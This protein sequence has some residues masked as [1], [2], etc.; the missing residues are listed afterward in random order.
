MLRLS[1]DKKQFLYDFCWTHKSSFAVL[2]FV[3]AFIATP[4]ACSWQVQNATLAAQLASRSESLRVEDPAKV[5]LSALL[6]AE[7]LIRLPTPEADHTLRSSLALL[8][9]SFRTVTHRGAI[10]SL[11]LSPDGLWLA[12]GSDDR[13]AEVVLLN[14]GE[15]LAPLIHE[16]RITQVEFSPDGALLASAGGKTIKILDLIHKRELPPITVDGTVLLLSFGGSNRLAVATSHFVTV[17]NALTHEQLAEF[18]R[19]QGVRSVRV[20]ISGRFIAIASGTT[21]QVSSISPKKDFPPVDTGGTARLMRFNPAGTLVAIAMTEN[22][23]RI[24]NTATGVAFGQPL[25]VQGLISA[26]AFSEDGRL[27]AVAAGNTVVIF[28]VSDHCEEVSQIHDQYDILTI[29]FVG[30]GAMIAVA[31]G[32]RTVQVFESRS[33]RLIVNFI[34]PGPVIAMDVSNRPVPTVAIAAGKVAQVFSL[35]RGHNAIPIW[36]HLKIE[37]AAFSSNGRLIITEKGKA[38][39]LNV[40]NGGQLD[41]VPG[42]DYPISSISYSSDARFIVL[43]KEIRGGQ[44]TQ[45]FESRD[46]GAVLQSS[47]I[48]ATAVVAS[49]FSVDGYLL[50]IAGDNTRS[51][52]GENQAYLR[53]FRPSPLQQGGGVKICPGL[54]QSVAVSPN[55]Q[56]AAIGTS[57]YLCMFRLQQASEFRANYGKITAIDFS[58]DNHLIAIGSETGDIH[59]MDTT[60]AEVFNASNHESPVTA[61]QFD[62]DSTTLASLTSNGVLRVFNVTRKVQ[63]NRFPESRVRAFTF[64]NKHLITLLMDEPG[65]ILQT[66]PLSSGDLVQQACSILSR[67]LSRSEWNMYLGSEPYRKT[68]RNLP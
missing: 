64:R 3:Y 35:S 39:V 52:Y 55:H 5:E 26:L 43:T 59:V 12:T 8:R 4:T 11:S 25:H 16:H 47:D 20:D 53:I 15:S 36:E 66:H 32:N 63:I 29:A 33:T 46:G 37:R 1:S 22:S 65:P 14:T 61:V 23:V 18:D 13:T 50:A 9:K 56:F 49:A 24:Y 38:Y 42:S 40:E 31:H 54:A 41:I 28:M 2:I 68:C 48:Q 17:Y 45:L 7:S 34:H 19:K 51:Q 44:I 57:S 62:Q 21:V 60:G 30:E 6:S 67:N 10:N 27:I 58:P